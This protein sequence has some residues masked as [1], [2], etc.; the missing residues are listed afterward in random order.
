MVIDEDAEEE[1][2]TTLTKNVMNNRSAVNG[3]IEEATRTH[4]YNIYHV[5]A[6]RYHMMNVS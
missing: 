1:A 4:R 5:P 3:A 2:Y 6:E